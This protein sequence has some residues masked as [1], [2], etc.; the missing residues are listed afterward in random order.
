VTAA[1]VIVVVAA[2]VSCIGAVVCVTAASL[3]RA[4]VR[5]LE[6]AI[7]SLEDDAVPMV[8]EARQA[9]D[10][11]SSEMARVEAVLE[12]TESVT[13]TVESASRLAQR[14][15]SNPV[16]KV[17]ALRAGAATGLRELRR[18]AGPAAR[19]PADPPHR[20]AGRR[21]RRDTTKKDR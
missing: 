2:S 9:V 11:A 20:G 7:E 3:L 21:A 4:H 18:P 8:S 15:F 16:V 13:Q 17:L 10:A 1:E 12:G 5:R 14:A 19:A 6:R